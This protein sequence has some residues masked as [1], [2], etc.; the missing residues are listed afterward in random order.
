MSITGA[1]FKAQPPVGRPAMT[2]VG[3]HHPARRQRGDHFQTGYP[4]QHAPR[5]SARRGTTRQRAGA[6]EDRNGG[7]EGRIDPHSALR[8]SAHHFT[9][10][11]PSCR[12]G[13][14]RSIP[15]ARLFRRDSGNAVSRMWCRRSPCG[16]KTGRTRRRAV[17]EASKGT[18]DPDGGGTPDANELAMGGNGGASGSSHRAFR[19]AGRSG[20]GPMSNAPSGNSSPG[21]SLCGRTSPA[22]MPAPSGR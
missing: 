11:K 18:H 10:P 5:T 9:Q 2:Q 15:P 22:R 13:R 20:R 17:V 3:G 1:T 21:R 6:V 8:S 14:T 12:V 4:E 7:P 16:R 19:T